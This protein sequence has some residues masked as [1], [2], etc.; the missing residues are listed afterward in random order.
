[1]AKVSVIIPTKNRSKDLTGVLDSLMNQTLSKTD[2]E[3]LVIDNGSTDD[4]ELVVSSYAGKIPNLKYFLEDKPG[5]HNGRHRGLQEASSSLLTFADDDIEAFPTWLSSIVESFNDSAIALVG[6]K[7]LPKFESAPPFWL[8]EMWQR[9]RMGGRVLGELSILD[10]G[11]EKL[12]IDPHLVF[13]CNFSIRK[14][15][16]IDA[17]GFHPDGMP[18]EMIHLRGD[19]ESY[20]S[21]YL[22]GNRLKA[23]YNPQASVYHKVSSNRMTLDY[24]K[25]RSYM[26]G[27]SDAYTS[28]R[29]GETKIAIPH[30][31]DSFYRRLRN[32]LGRV[33]N[34]G[35]EIS[36]LRNELSKTEFD[37]EIERSYRLGSEYI[38]AL[39]QKEGEVREWVHRTT[40]M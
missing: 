28:L 21:E 24:F 31:E 27:I 32:R 34:V 5:L 22:K 7:N 26:Q 37:K 15:V 19:G 12:E 40:Y 10:L 29:K 16:L 8:V 36:E 23:I 9:E 25:K 3:V 39:Y 30:N 18:W 14:E 35:D 11:K 20:I 1:M 13:G 33:L 17:G 38:K 4:T 2:F 6:G